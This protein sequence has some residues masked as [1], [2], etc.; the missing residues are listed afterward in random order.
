MCAY[1]WPSSTIKTT[2]ASC[3]IYY[4]LNCLLCN[5]LCFFCPSFIQFYCH[6]PLCFPLFDLAPP[7]HQI[8]FWSFE[9]DRCRATR[10]VNN[11]RAQ[12]RRFT[13]N[14]SPLKFIQT[15]KHETFRCHSQ[16]ISQLIMAV[17]TWSGCSLLTMLPDTTST[18][19]HG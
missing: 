19:R 7:K 9:P 10:T 14:S 13:I 17:A 15:T 1:S 5:Y 16:L 12:R 8:F 18:I 6:A 2:A 3:L 4:S 11:W